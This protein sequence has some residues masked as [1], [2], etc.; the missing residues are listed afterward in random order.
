M[1]QESY[2]QAPAATNEARAQ[3]YQEEIDRLRLKIEQ[4]GEKVTAIGDR[5][6]LLLGVEGKEDVI[7]KLEAQQT[8]LEAQQ[9]EM[10]S[11]QTKLEALLQSLQGRFVV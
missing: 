7:A 5:I 1:S 10:K 9:A 4:Y 3:T 2:P 8:R 11:Q 6:L